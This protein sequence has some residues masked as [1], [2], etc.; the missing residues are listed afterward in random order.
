MYLSRGPE[1]P[2][3]DTGLP[4]SSDA[5][6]ENM[7]KVLELWQNYCIERMNV[8]YEKYKFNNRAQ[9]ANES[10]DAYTTALRTLT[11]TCEMVR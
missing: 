3:I 4:F 7:D 10:I 8:I 6:R 9:E 2:E 5:E 11:E 1:A